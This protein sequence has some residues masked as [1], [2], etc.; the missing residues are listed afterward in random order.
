VLG[1]SKRAKPPGALAIY[2][3]WSEGEESAGRFE[4]PLTA[5]TYKAFW[6]N[7]VQ[8]LLPQGLDWHE[9]GPEHVR[10]VLAGPAPGTGRKRPPKSVSKM[11]N[12]TRYRYW[13][14]LR[15]VYLHACEENFLSVNPALIG[16]DVPEIN[17][18]DRKAQ[19]LPPGVLQ[20]LRKPEVL[21]A[22]LPG[23]PDAPHWS[24]ARDR[25]MVALA[26]HCG[27]TTLE[28]QVLKPADLKEGSA[29]MRPY[30]TGSLKG[31]PLPTVIVD[32]PRTRKHQDEGFRSLDV[33]HEIHALL[34][35]WVAQRDDA[36]RVDAQHLAL[37]GVKAHERP[38][39][40]A[41]PLF[42]SRQKHSD[43]AP[44]PAMEAQT[45]YLAI[46]RCLEAAYARPKVRALLGDAKVPKGAAIIRNAVILDWVDNLGES[47]ATKLAGHK[48]AESLRSITQGTRS[49]KRPVRLA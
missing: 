27:L 33:P 1:V 13:R 46:R 15:G 26:A 23:N 34:R 36:L 4:D 5:A 32:V 37:A 21:R 43:T 18:D 41:Y 28:L 42:I 30:P 3:R 20:M 48:S 17:S 49:P 47:E 11:A 14:I 19:A 31:L 38:G 12:T 25:A 45:I 10:A 35:E 40:N 22:L 7:W 6:E 39:P 9:A 44:L 16:E 24:V 8:F 2:A 29:A